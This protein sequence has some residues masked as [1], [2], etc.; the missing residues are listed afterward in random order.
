MLK[1]IAHV[2]FV[3]NTTYVKVSN[4]MGTSSELVPVV[5]NAVMWEALARATTSPMRTQVRGLG[6]LSRARH[7]LRLWTH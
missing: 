5:S 1:R 4:S 3:S 2:R 7:R 6:V